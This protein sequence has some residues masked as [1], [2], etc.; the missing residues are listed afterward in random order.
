MNEGTNHQTK[1]KERKKER[2]IDKNV[3]E[4]GSLFESWEKVSAR[5]F[6]K[7]IIIK[8]GI[9]LADAGRKLNILISKIVWYVI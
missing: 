6:K 2:K 9:W 3:G 4:I 8:S 7:I 5:N 1:K